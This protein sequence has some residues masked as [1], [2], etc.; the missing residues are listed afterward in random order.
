[1]KKFLATTLLLLCLSLAILVVPALAQ[2]EPTPQPAPEQTLLW[3]VIGWLLYSILGLVASVAQDQNFDARKFA[4]SFLWFVIVA[5]L[6]I[7]MKLSPTQVATQNATIVQQ[8]VDILMN[9]SVGLTLIYSLD[10]LY[11]TIINVSKKLAPQPT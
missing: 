3:T 9:S 5:V 11:I 10:K 4:R 7:G 6:A 1:L 2:E 8:I